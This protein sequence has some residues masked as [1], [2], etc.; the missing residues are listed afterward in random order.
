M[1][2]GGKKHVYYTAGYHYY[3]GLHLVI[4]HGPIDLITKIEVGELK[5][6]EGSQ[7]AGT[8]FLN[9]ENLFGGDVE[10]KEGGVRGC[11]DLDFGGA[12]QG[13]NSYLADKLQNAPAFRG[14]FSMILKQI[15]VGTSPY[16]KPWVVYA[17]RIHTRQNGIAQWYDAKAAIDTSEMNPIH[18]IRECLTDPYWGMGYAEADVDETS[19]R[20]AA[21]T[22]YTEGWGMSILWD[23]S[24]TLDEFI[25]IVLKHINAYLYISRST[26]K[27]MIKLVREDY[28]I[29][30]LMVLDESC[31]SSIDDFKR[32]G[33]AELVNSIS[34]QFWDRNTGK[35][36]AVT[37]FDEAVA[38]AQ[39]AQV[40][41]TMQYNG[42]TTPEL[43]RRAALRDLVT[44]S[45][46]LTGCVLYASRKA[47]NLN[48]GDAFKL[49]WPRYGI[50]QMIMRVMEIELGELSDNK[51]RIVAMEDVFGF[52]DSVYSDVYVPE[53]EPLGQEPA[54]C[55]IHK[56]IEAPYYAVVDAMGGDTFADLILKSLD[57]YFIATGTIPNGDASFAQLWSKVGADWVEQSSTSFCP[58]ALLTEA[59]TPGQTAITIADE[60]GADHPDIPIN[61][62]ALLDDEIIKIV[63]IDVNAGTMTIGRGCLDTVPASHAFGARIFF[64]TPFFG[65]DAISYAEGQ[66]AYVKL[67]P[68][69]SKG[70]LDIASAPQQTLTFV[71]RQDKPY[72]PG[73]LRIATQAYPTRL[74]PGGASIDIS[75]AHRDRTQ[76][77]ASIYDTEYGN[78]GPEVDVTY[79]L[80]LRTAAGTLLDHYHDLAGTSQ[81]VSWATLAA[82]AGQNVKVRLWA[83]RGS[84]AEPSFQTHEWTFELVGYGLDYGNDYG[85]M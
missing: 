15:Y 17:R 49:V 30:D 81:A 64:I 6:W 73:K 4:C 29:G 82:T 36:S 75:W 69:T 70:A 24:I 28:V 71:G 3:V 50:E 14:V 23:Q 47:A 61:G 63:A 59:I 34:V 40:N 38:A 32:A 51:V 66:T 42:F 85:G 48:V 45:T 84:A 74:A 65:T 8:F 39:G 7:G 57:N 18:I 53:W 52:D 5:A 26:G 13:V 37:V 35:P 22:I 43:A 25:N 58:T 46:P 21:D 10:G 2:G 55:P 11:I 83:E 33:M 80:E 31:I 27:F 12:A 1:G 79:E 41:A 19:F 56:V 67:L 16:L 72:P 44:M 60:N 77:T 68:V 20:A 78:V 9:A 54:P 76:Q 62:W